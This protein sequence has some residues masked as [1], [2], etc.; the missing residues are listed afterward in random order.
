MRSSVATLPA[1]ARMLFATSGPNKPASNAEV[2]IEGDEA[3][4]QSIAALFRDLQPDPA[5]PLARTIGR[6]AADN[7]VGAAEAG[8][9]FLRSAAESLAAG[10]RKEAQDAWLR[11]STGRT[12]FWIGWT[13]SSC[14][15]IAWMPE[16]G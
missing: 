14:A 12:R 3:V 7:L 5:E 15:W 13:N 11:P 4:L 8:F 9:A 10:A 16:S 2:R 1:I 6:D